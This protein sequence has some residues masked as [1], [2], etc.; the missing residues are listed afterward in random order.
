MAPWAEEAALPHGG[1]GPMSPTAGLQ[2]GLNCT[3]RFSV[4]AVPLRY[5]RYHLWLPVSDICTYAELRVQCCNCQQKPGTELQ[6]R[7][8]RRSCHLG[9]AL[10]CSSTH[11]AAAC[12]TGSTARSQVRSVMPV[13]SSTSWHI[14]IGPQEHGLLLMLEANIPP[15][16]A[17]AFTGTSAVP[18]FCSLRLPCVQGVL[19]RWR[20]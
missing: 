12:T 13:Q 20:S 15:A 9:P 6:G 7:M 16:S 10:R 4:Q 14:E 19:T 3:R 17:A 11:A 8:T 2:A 1:A 5:S 18:A